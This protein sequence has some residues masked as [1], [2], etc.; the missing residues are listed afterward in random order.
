MSEADSRKSFKFSAAV[1][2]R[3]G[4]LIDR[5]PLNALAF[6]YCYQ[7]VLLKQIHTNPHHSLPRTIPSIST[8]TNFALAKSGISCA[9]KAGAFGEKAISDDTPTQVAA[10]YNQ[11]CAV[12]GSKCQYFPGAIDL[13][14]DLQQAG[15]QN[16]ISSALEQEVL[17]H[18]LTS[19]QG[20]AL[21]PYLAENL[22]KRKDFAKGKDHFAHVAK[23]TQR[24]IPEP[25][26]YVADARQEIMQAKSCQ[27]SFN[28]LIVGFAH[29][30][31]REKFAQADELILTSI[32]EHRHLRESALGVYL[33]N[34]AG[35]AEEQGSPL[36]LSLKVLELPDDSGL[37]G[38]GADL[39]V[40]GAGS[41]IFNLLRQKLQAPS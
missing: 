30:L 39:L 2:I 6:A 16:F 21:A 28:L 25:I 10:L 23:L 17:D 18:W 29:C 4:V 20:L 40:E 1:W 36:K 32:N 3:D 15:V 5:M 24:Q 9:D 27:T 11:L 19:K 31:K 7:A 37:A 26:L 14:K 12:A 34:E 35:R 33:N 8:L 38:A 22:G 13:L 41:E